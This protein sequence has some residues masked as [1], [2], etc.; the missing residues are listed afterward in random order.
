MRKRDEG[1]LRSMRMLWHSAVARRDRRLVAF[2]DDVAYSL[3]E[4]LELSKRWDFVAYMGL[5]MLK[6]SLRGLRE[7][8]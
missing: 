7:A 8:S 4:H 6:E 1:L 3:L 2:R 5:K